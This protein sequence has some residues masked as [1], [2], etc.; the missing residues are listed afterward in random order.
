MPVPGG[1]TGKS[2]VLATLQ[3]DAPA[4]VAVNAAVPHRANGTITI[5]LTAKAIPAGV[6]V[7]WFVFGSRG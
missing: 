3:T 5:H 2:H 1:L 7:A 6:K 4:N